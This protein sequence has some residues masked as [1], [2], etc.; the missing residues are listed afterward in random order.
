MDC[1][2]P[3]S[4]RAQNPGW[5]G[6]LTVMQQI[7][8]KHIIGFTT[9]PPLVHTVF[10]PDPAEVEATDPEFGRC[11]AAHER[12]SDLRVSFGSSSSLVSSSAPD[13]AAPDDVEGCGQRAFACRRL[14][15]IAAGASFFAPRRASAGASPEIGRSSLAGC[16]RQRWAQVSSR[17]DHAASQVVHSRSSPLASPAPRPRPA[18]L[19]RG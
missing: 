19:R 11:R 2:R 6:I 8:R 4:S 10:V 3:W 1:W 12:Q 17:R 9:P 16:H 5:G 13:R 15:L 18:D 14:Q 7:T